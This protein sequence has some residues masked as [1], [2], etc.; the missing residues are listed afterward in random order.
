[1]IIIDDSYFHIICSRIHFKFRVEFASGSTSGCWVSF[2]LV[3]TT[4]W[5]EARITEL[6]GYLGRGGSTGESGRSLWFKWPLRHV[7]NF[8]MFD[9]KNVFH[10]FW[11]QSFKKESMKEWHGW[12]PNLYYILLNHENLKQFFVGLSTP[13]LLLCPS[14]A[15]RITLTKFTGWGQCERSDQ[16][17]LRNDGGHQGGTFWGDPQR[18]R[19]VGGWESLV[20]GGFCFET[21][22]LVFFGCPVRNY[23]E[24][25]KLDV[26]EGMVWDSCKKWVGAFWKRSPWFLIWRW[27]GFWEQVCNITSCNTSLYR[28]LL[29]ME[30]TRLLSRSCFNSSPAAILCFSPRPHKAKPLDCMSHLA[31]FFFQENNLWSGHN[32]YPFQPCLVSLRPPASQFSRHSSSQE[33]R[34]MGF[35]EG[36]KHPRFACI[37]LIYIYISY[38]YIYTPIIVLH[39]HYSR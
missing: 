4:L 34:V 33:M 7:P 21:F 31:S 29:P 3:P 22:P 25:W 30:R 39:S 27:S 38:V 12:K 17:S 13:F 14:V 1:M 5:V 10:H 8:W 28:R 37:L 24:L 2:T 18:E 6:P 36:R 26:T 19:L 9:P 32:L 16:S 15:V 23:Y 20:L 11:F 35:L